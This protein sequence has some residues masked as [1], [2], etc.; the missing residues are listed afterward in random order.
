MCILEDQNDF[1]NNP[2]KVRRPDLINS[3]LDMDATANY[4][5]LASESLGW[6][7]RPKHPIHQ[8]EVT[9]I[10][11]AVSCMMN[12]V[13]ASTH[14][15]PHM[16]VDAQSWM[17]VVHIRS[18]NSNTICVVKWVGMRNRT[19]KLG[20]TCNIPSIG[21]NAKPVHSKTPFVYLRIFQ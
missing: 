15:W 4:D 13:V 19:N 5:A 11:V 20:V 14:N 16:F 10:I 8:Y 2:K 7:R 1:M 18:K 17:L 3:Q 9:A 21:C 12:G 6:R